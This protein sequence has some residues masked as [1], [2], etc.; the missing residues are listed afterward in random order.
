MPEY[1]PMPRETQP[2]RR[3]S[4][5]HRPMAQTDWYAVAAFVLPPILSV[6]RCSTRGL[7]DAVESLTP[8]RG[9]AEAAP[10]VRQ[11]LYDHGAYLAHDDGAWT[12]AKGRALPAPSAELGARYAVVQRAWDAGRKLHN[13]SKH[14]GAA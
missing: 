1:R 8:N 10:L 13:A 4:Y 11:W 2:R 14:R 5:R 9:T 6:S 3:P 7:V 12:V